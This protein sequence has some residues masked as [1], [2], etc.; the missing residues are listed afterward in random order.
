MSDTT[1]LHKWWEG[2]KYE[3]GVESMMKV[4]EG[5]DLPRKKITKMFEKEFGKE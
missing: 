3:E 2:K 5:I 1:K 4:H